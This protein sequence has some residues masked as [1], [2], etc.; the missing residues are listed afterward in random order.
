MVV[1]YST[2]IERKYLYI[3][4]S[5]CP[6]RTKPKLSSFLHQDPH[7]KSPFG[8][9][10]RRVFQV[11]GADV[12]PGPLS[13]KRPSDIAS[14]RHSKGDLGGIFAGHVDKGSAGLAALPMSPTERSVTML[15]ACR[16]MLLFS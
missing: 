14:K 6:T 11:K 3:C 4:C 2:E 8:P 1:K 10:V 7:E 15:S 13:L 5:T 9:F 12:S 16:P